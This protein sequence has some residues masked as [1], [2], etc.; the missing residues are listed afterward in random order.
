[1]DIGL[2]IEAIDTVCE[3]YES[4]R[5]EELMAT[6]KGSSRISDTQI[7]SI[8]AKAQAAREIRSHLMTQL[9]FDI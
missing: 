6:T 8:L 7:P 1:M 9:G 4:R 2:V 3:T 5:I